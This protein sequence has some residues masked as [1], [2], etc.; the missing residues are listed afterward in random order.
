VHPCDQRL[1]R[2]RPIERA[3]LPRRA[4]ITPAGELPARAAEAVH[5]LEPGAATGPGRLC[6]ALAIDTRLS[7]HH[8]FER[9]S[10]LYLREGTP[11]RRIGVSARIGI[12]QA[13][14]R[15]LRFFDAD[16]PAVSPF[17]A[18]PPSLPAARR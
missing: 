6:R 15:P 11:T 18:A 14:E 12:R 16:S 7:G 9:A 8:L 10:A 4:E 3:P 1:D 5:G 2:A 17:R 13:A